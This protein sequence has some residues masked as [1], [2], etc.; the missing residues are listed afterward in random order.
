MGVPFR[1]YVITIILLLSIIVCK[2]EFLNPRFLGFVAIII[3]AYSILMFYSVILRGNALSNFLF[4]LKPLLIF[5]ITPAYSFL[6]KKYGIKKYLNWFVYSTIGIILLFIYILIRTIIDPSFGIGLN[7]SSNLI[8]VAVYDFLPR[9]V[10]DTFVFI[11]PMAVYLMEKSKGTRIHLF[12]L[13]MLLT[14]L[15]SMTFG[16]VLVIIIMYLVILYKKYS[17]KAIIPFVIVGCLGYF[18][19][20]GF[21]QDTI[22]ETKGDSASFKEAQVENINK[23]MGAIE[24]LFGRGLG[25]VFKDYD[26]RNE[27]EPIIEV[28]GVQIYQSGGLLF[29]W[30]ILFPYIL[31]VIPFALSSRSDINEQML[32]LSQIGI[33]LASFANPYIWS[34]SVGLLFMLLFVSYRG[35][36]IKKKQWIIKYQ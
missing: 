31:P 32:S 8:G 3:V 2:K 10:L 27:N 16:L 28:A 7:E 6:F 21:I 25:C 15:L 35:S 17:L 9:I 18:T 22:I 33:F 26:G 11:I 24:L 30:L 12:F 19:Y 14:A 5:V 34:G 13:V 36:K 4:F 20:V 23:N 29:M 1:Y